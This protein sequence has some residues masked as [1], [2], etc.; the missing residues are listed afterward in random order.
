MTS[1]GR[2]DHIAMALDAKGDIVRQ[3]CPNICLYQ[4]YFLTIHSSSVNV[5]IQETRRNM[6][7]ADLNEAERIA[8]LQYAE[9]PRLK[10]V[11]MGANLA[12]ELGWCRRPT[13]GP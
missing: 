13:G 6:G 10:E 8:V 2:I 3:I 5:V 7:F 4:S 11:G 12:A 9:D 1:K